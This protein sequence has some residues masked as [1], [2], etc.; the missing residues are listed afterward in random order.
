MPTPADQSFLYFAYGS[1]LL[2]RRLLERTP[3]AKKV[4]T[5]LLRGYERRWHEASLD[6]SGKCD[7]HFVGDA[8]SHVRGVVYQI[9]L[10][11]KP[12]LD[13]AETLGVG[14]DEKLAPIETTTGTLSA[15]LY[16]ALKIDADAVPYD[17]YHALVVSGAEEHA[18][19]PS[20]LQALRAVRTKPDEDKARSARYFGLAN[21]V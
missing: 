11:E 15:W 3:S 21:A 14:Y 4:A 7:V 16:Y 13:A 18:F 1:N 10:A 17:W 20:Y 8:A 9:E 2:T 5:G 6:G 12:V 19:P